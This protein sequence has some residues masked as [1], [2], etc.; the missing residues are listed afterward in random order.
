MDLE[1][2]RARA[3][4]PALAGAA[5][6]AAVAQDLA[7]AFAEDVLFDWLSRADRPPEALRRRFFRRVVQSALRDGSR[8]ERPASGGAAAIWSPSE[9]LGAGSLAEEVKDLHAGLHLTG[10]RRLP[11][12]IAVGKDME[13]HH[14]M[15][16][17]HAYL[18]FLG[19]ARRFQGQGVGSWLLRSATDRLDRSRRPAFLES[20]SE[21][22]VALYRRHGF[23]V[24]STH[25]A[26]PDAPLVWSMWREPAPLP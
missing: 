25:R 8:I 20:Q 10:W 2:L 16:R 21:R 15:T 13:A 19:V 12:L 7:D 22:N 18:W 3:Q 11:R 23:Q 1:G 24:I 14:P 26:R 17:P 6:L 9:A 5:D 4:A